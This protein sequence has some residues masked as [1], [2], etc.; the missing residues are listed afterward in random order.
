MA[1]VSGSFDIEGES[2]PIGLRLQSNAAFPVGLERDFRIRTAHQLAA[3]NLLGLNP[4]VPEELDLDI[5]DWLPVGSGNLDLEIRC[6]VRETRSRWRLR[7]RGWRRSRANSRNPDAS[8]K[9]HQ[10]QREPS[11]AASVPMREMHGLFSVEIADF[12]NTGST[13][14]ILS[15]TE[16]FNLKMRSNRGRN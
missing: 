6:G 5:G 12:G 2:L 15:C 4:L 11:C 3:L 8:E 1:R 9:N 16:F 14:Q 10:P 7:L 13:F